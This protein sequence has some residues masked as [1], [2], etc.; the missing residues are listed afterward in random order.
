MKNMLLP[1]MIRGELLPSERFNFPRYQF[2]HGTMTQNEIGQW[3]V[4]YNEQKPLRLDSA[5]EAL[6]VEFDELGV[7]TLMKVPRRKW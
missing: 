3:E 6:Y 5:T 1:V 2:V 4:R 7:P